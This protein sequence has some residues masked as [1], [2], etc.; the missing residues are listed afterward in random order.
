MTDQPTLYMLIGVPGSGKSTW[1]AKQQWASNCVL[2]STDKFIDAYAL[3]I[4]KTYNDV[5]TDYIKT[6][7][8]MLSKLAI[9][10]TV[11]ETS[12]IWDQ[13]NLSIKSRRDKIKLFLG[14]KRIA[15]VFPTPNMEELTIRLASR[16][17]KHISNKVIT[18][19]INSF[20]M[21]TTEEGFDEI[22]YT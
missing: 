3:S 12:A 8:Q 21:P 13:T 10:T 14:Y 15:V 16:P 1:V 5:F 4:G 19:M 11:A 7:T 6:A 18:S 20:Q 9:T 2:L 22:W 17:G